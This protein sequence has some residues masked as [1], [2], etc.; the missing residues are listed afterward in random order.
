MGMNETC[1][2]ASLMRA[3]NV[4]GSEMQNARIRNMRMDEKAWN[5]KLKGHE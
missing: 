4:P 1:L 5:K 2:I 3:T